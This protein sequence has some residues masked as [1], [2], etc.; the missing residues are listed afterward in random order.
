LLASAV[1]GQATPLFLNYAA[2]VLQD[3]EVL[4]TREKISY[5]VDANASGSKGQCNSYWEGRSI[6]IL[7]FNEMTPEWKNAYDAGIFTEFMEQRAP[8]THGVG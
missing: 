1:R 5:S 2:T 6:R 7:I 4:N 3:F 8:R